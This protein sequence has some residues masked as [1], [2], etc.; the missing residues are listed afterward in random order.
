MA[1]PIVTFEFNNRSETFFTN[2]QRL[3]FRFIVGGLMLDDASMFK[4]GK[5]HVVTTYNHTDKSL[6][7]QF[8]GV[9]GNYLQHMVCEFPF[10]VSDINYLGDSAILV[11][12]YKIKVEIETVKTI[13]I[14]K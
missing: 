1:R 4:D 12:D 14:S 13:S 7:M 3:L 6:K 10:K 11:F 9:N 8:N 5:L 2:F